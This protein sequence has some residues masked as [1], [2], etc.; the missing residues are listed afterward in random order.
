MHTAGRNVT[1]CSHCAKPCGGAPAIEHGTATCPS[2]PT[3]GCIHK[4]AK[5]GTH[6]AAIK[7]KGTLTP[8]TTRMNLEDIVLSEIS[9]SQKDR[10]CLITPAGHPRG[11]KFRDRK[12]NGGCR[13]LGEREVG[14]NGNK[15]LSL[16]RKNV[17]VWMVVIGT[18]QC[19]CMNASKG[20]NGEKLCY[21]NFTTIKNKIR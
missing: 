12:Q 5:A 8:A 6:Q 11:V 15:S 17:L 1:Q 18:Q 9:R 14:I 7:R 19:E 13:R 3:S 16:G 10:Y 2:N 4:E 21:I 20:R